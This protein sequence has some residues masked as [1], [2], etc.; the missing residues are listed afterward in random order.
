MTFPNVSLRT[1][2]ASGLLGGQWL[3]GQLDTQRIEGLV[4]RLICG[5]RQSGTD[6]LH[7][8][9]LVFTS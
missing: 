7:Q 8:Y 4:Q 2:A 9:R 1:A 6:G 5:L 3:L